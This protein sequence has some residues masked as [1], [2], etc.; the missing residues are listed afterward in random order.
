MGH[1]CRMPELDPC[2]KLTRLK[3]EGTRR[4]EKSELKWLESVEEQ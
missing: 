4:V 1:L 3:P 2:R